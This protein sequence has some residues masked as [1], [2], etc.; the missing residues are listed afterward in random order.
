MPNKQDSMLADKFN[1]PMITT[2]QTVVANVVT[3]ASTATT[4]V[5]YTTTAQADAIVA[6]INAIN[7]V[8]V[9]HGLM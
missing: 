6:A 9:A 2:K 4:P 5:G 7:A 1:N 3:T 8:L